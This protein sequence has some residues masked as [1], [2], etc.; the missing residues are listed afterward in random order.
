MTTLLQERDNFSLLPARPP[1]GVVGRTVDEP[2]LITWK[3]DGRIGAVDLHHLPA[4]TPLTIDTTN[5][6]YHVVLIDPETG[7]AKVQGGCLFGEATDIWFEGATD[8]F[9][10]PEPG[11]V[12]VG[13]NLA[14]RLSERRGMTSRVTGIAVHF[15][16]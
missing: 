12:R 9:D 16:S 15:L 5:S 14:F 3:E 7:R 6:R 8:R 11:I 2:A 13:L 4:G 10:E 1:R